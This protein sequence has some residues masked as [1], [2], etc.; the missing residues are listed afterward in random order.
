MVYHKTLNIVLYTRKTSRTLLS[1][2][3]TYNSLHLLIP[4][5]DSIPPLAPSSLGN[6][7]SVPYVGESA[8]AS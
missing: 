7:W 8:A 5:S 3:S 6:H 1:I 4:A 2:P